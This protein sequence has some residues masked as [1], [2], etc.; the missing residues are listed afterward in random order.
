MTPPFAVVVTGHPGAGKT[1]FAPLLARTLSAVCLSREMIS[2]ALY[3]GWEPRH[4]A[5]DSPEYIAPVVGD[6]YFAESKVSWTI[7]LSMFTEISRVAT[8]VAESPFNNAAA[9][10]RFLA[11]RAL[12]EV[13]VV[14]VLLHAPTDVLRKR[15]LARAD[16]PEA[17]PTKRTWTI[18]GPPP[19]VPFDPVLPSGPTISVDATSLPVDVE[20][21]RAGVLAAVGGQ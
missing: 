9:R 21:V 14:E 3:G 11:V 2:N 16:D 17:H 10:E 19:L 8:L 15:M 6:A 4:P 13:P 18:A 5:A 1:T 20:R 7:F 12:L